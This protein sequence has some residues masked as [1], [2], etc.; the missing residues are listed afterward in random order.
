MA[1]QTLTVIVPDRLYSRI[2]HRAEKANR[3]VEAELLDVLATAVPGD[4]ELP[5]DLVESIA[6]LTLL[7]DSALWHAARNCLDLPTS[8]RLEHLHL[9][10]QKDGLTRIEDDEMNDLMRRYERAILVRARAVALLQQR[11]QDIS[12]LVAP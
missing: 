12:S 9:K 4:E 5:R 10:R 6:S 8:A 2:Q 1:T 3:T 7:D 11:G